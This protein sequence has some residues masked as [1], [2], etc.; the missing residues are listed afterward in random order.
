[1][2]VS[3]SGKTTIARPLADRLGWPLEEG[4]DLHPAANVAK[5]KAGI[6]LDDADR[7]PWLAAIA[8][9]IAERLRAGA[10]ASS[11]ARPCAAPIATGCARPVRGVTFVFLEGSK[12]VI[13][14]RMTARHGHFIAG[15][16]TR[17]PVRD[18]GGADPRR[19]RHRGGRRPDRESSGRRDRSGYRAMTMAG[20]STPSS[21]ARVGRPDG[22]NL[23]GPLPPAG[24]GDRRR[25]Q[26]GELDPHQPQPPRI[27]RW[28]HGEDLLARM[29]AQATKYGATIPGRHGRSVCEPKTPAGFGSTSSAARR[30]ARLMCSWRQG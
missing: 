18:P 8:A 21:S 13:A 5:M 29:R 10:A 7:A 26:P 16:P 6:P 24:A 4:D 9:W 14:A 28:I 20:C 3:G 11:P 30:S 27:S 19:A 23:S 25:R 12:P 22:G 1:M 15:D 17:Q 2:G